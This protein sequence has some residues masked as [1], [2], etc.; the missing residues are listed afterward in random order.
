MN[1]W[2]EELVM[3][4]YIGEK[5]GEEETEEDEN[6]GGLEIGFVTMSFLVR[7]QGLCSTMIANEFLD[8]RCHCQGW[9]ERHPMF[10]CSAYCKD[11]LGAMPGSLA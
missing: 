9:N 3:R 10:L 6:K 1:I 7:G 5:Y 4:K 11:V 2:D 8:L